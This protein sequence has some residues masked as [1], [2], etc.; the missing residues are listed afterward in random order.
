MRAGRVRVGP[1]VRLLFFSPHYGTVGG[2]RSIIDALAAAARAAGHEVSAIVDG[3]G[4]GTFG[5]ERD[6]LLYPFPARARELRRLRRFAQKFPLRAMRLVSAV[7]AARRRRTAGRD[8]PQRLRPGGVPPWVALPPPAPLRARPRPA[9]GAE[10]LRSPDRG[11]RAARGAR[12]RP[13]ACGRRRRAP[14]AEGPGA[15][16]RARRPRSFP[17]C[18]RP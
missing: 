2:V 13:R 11:A 8:R 5:R 7:R 15:S 9:R 16:P 1:C 17:R 10:G 3:G 6:L 4:P 12:A 14:G 18:G